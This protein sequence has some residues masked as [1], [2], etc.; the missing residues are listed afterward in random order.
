MDDWSYPDNIETDLYD[1]SGITMPV[2]LIIGS[3]DT[4]CAPERAYEL[5]KEL[6]N[7]QNVITIRGADHGL[8]MFNGKKFYK[9]LEAE[10]T[11]EVGHYETLKGWKKYSEDLALL[12][13]TSEDIEDSSS[14]K[15]DVTLA[16]CGALSIALIGYCVFARR[17]AKKSTDDF[18]RA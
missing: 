4:Q 10:C 1:L 6:S 5:A 9:L 13:T 12:S 18:Q 8:G 7:V 15:L 11:P 3:K 16:A 2:S 17:G 14:G